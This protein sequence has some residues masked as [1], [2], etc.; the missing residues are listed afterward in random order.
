MRARWSGEQRDY[1]SDALALLHGWT[2]EG[3]E[4]RRTLQL[5][6]SQ[7]AAL[8]ERMKIVADAL[9]VRPDVR[10]LDGRTQIRLRT[11]DGTALTSGEVTLAARIEDL[12][13]TIMDAS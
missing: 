12:Y 2:R 7:H 5:D 3:M 4:L 8:T 1:L 10:R 6:E 11:P 13:R 9:Q